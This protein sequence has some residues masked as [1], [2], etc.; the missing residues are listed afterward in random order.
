MKFS[1]DGKMLLLQ[2]RSIFSDNCATGTLDGQQC[3]AVLRSCHDNMVIWDFV[4]YGLEWCWQWSISGGRLC[5]ENQFT[6][7]SDKAIAL[8]EMTLLNVVPLCLCHAKEVVSSLFACGVNSRRKFFPEMQ[9]ADEAD[10]IRESAVKSDFFSP[11]EPLALQVGFLSFQRVMTLVRF[12]GTPQS[13][14][15]SVSAI[16]DFAGW[17]LASGATTSGEVLTVAVATDPF[18]LLEEWA[19]LAAAII[20]PRFRRQPALGISGGAWGLGGFANVEEFKLGNARRAV[21]RLQGF[22]LE[23]VWIS[24]ANLPGGN[25][26]SGRNGL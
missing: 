17:R 11:L 18:L 23:F 5:V 15:A 16:T 19:E 7:R 12:S 9:L 21:E 4:G 1:F 24:I 13:D 14:V 2:D 3:D 10:A 20:K 25:P 26:G 6:N 22:G 8:G